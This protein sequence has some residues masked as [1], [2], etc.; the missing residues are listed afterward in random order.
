MTWADPEA[1]QLGAGRV[2]GACFALF[3]CVQEEDQ[4]QEED[5]MPRSALQRL[6]KG[7]ERS[8]HRWKESRLINSQS[9]TKTNSTESASREAASAVSD[10][11]RSKVS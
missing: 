8:D 4:D 10:S 6:T 5:G 1:Q 9:S 2:C 3:S 7:Q 11:A